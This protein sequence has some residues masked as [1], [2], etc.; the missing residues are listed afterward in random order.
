VSADEPQPTSR[1]DEMAGGYARFWAPVLRAA[2]ERV[3]DPLAPHFNGR[4]DAELLDV[5]TGT[6]TLAIAALARWP[7][8]RVTGI[9]PS[10]GMLQVAGI[11]AAER[12]PTSGQRRFRRRVAP[13]DALPFPDGSFD[14]AMSSFVLQLV[15][16]RAAAL[17]EVR[18][19]LRPDGVMAWVAWQRTARAFEPDRIANEV[20][21][22]F[23][24]DPPEPDRRPGDIASPAS[25]AQS[26]R[27][28]G[29]SDVR[30]WVGECAYAWDAKGYLAFLTEFDEQSLF[31][32]LERDE[33]TEI[34]R[35]I[36]ARLKRLRP[37]R[38]TL[39][40]PVVYA[41]GRAGG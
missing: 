28:A 27:R 15:P 24:F 21:D 17:R 11:T 18:R 6:G 10:D 29:F 9:D 25:A 32:D 35:A 39:R 26:M 31:D 36:L 20:L 30:A 23:G 7:R 2:A 8:I 16:S 1:Y 41:T 14:A 33:R 5:G 34:E 22:E 38:L 40:L 19:V 13:A 4:P 12:L 3:L 37:E